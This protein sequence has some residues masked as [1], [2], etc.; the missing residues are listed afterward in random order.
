MSLSKRAIR[1]FITSLN[2][3]AEAYLQEDVYEDMLPLEDR[4][5]G[6]LQAGFSL[7]VINDPDKV[8]WADDPIVALTRPFLGGCCYDEDCYMDEFNE[9]VRK[10]LTASSK[11]TLGICESK[12]QE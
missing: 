3:L 12:K 10:L 11:K 7:G 8:P 6:M 2:K 5:K 4:L 1:R 9:C